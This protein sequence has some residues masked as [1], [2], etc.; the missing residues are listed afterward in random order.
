[1]HRRGGVHGMKGRGEGCIGG[2]G[3]E[4]CIRE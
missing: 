2:R 4:E 3:G 1:M